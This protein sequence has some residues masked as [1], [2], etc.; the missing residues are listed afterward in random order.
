MTRSDLI[1][2]LAA[3]FSHLTTKDAE[4]AVKEIQGEYGNGIACACL[5]SET[6]DE[7]TRKRCADCSDESLSRALYLFVAASSRTCFRNSTDDATRKIASR[8]LHR[9]FYAVWARSGQ[10]PFLLWMNFVFSVT[11]RAVNGQ[12]G[13]RPS[14]PL[15]LTECTVENVLRFFVRPK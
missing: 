14:A 5:Q 10:P 7:N 13:C 6:S 11:F 12:P 3:R 1:A 2:A 8:S 4:I 15:L 9:R